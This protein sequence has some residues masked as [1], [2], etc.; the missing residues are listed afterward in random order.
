V[1]KLVGFGGTGHVLVIGMVVNDVVFHFSR[2]EK[3]ELTVWALMN[4]DFVLH[5]LVM[6][7]TTG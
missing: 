2:V 4:D 1:G 7:R 3:L 5:V 6:A